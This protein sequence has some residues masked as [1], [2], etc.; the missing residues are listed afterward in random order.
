LS[1]SDDPVQLTVD[2]DPRRRALEAALDQ[3]S[4]RYGGAGVRPGSDLIRSKTRG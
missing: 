1:G 3:V 2:D 4:E